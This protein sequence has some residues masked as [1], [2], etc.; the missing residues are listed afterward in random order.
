MTENIALSFTLNLSY[1]ILFTD[2]LFE[3][4]NLL[5]SRQI[6][7]RFKQANCLVYID[8]NVASN[9]VDLTRNIVRYF[10]NKVFI[11]LSSSPYVIKGGEA[12]KNDPA[13]L[14]QLYMD[15]LDAGID[16]H[17]CI[18]AIGGG[19][20]LDLVGYAAAT[21]HRGVPLI[22]IPTTVLAQN[23]AGIGVKTGINF[24]G[25]KNSIGAFCTPLAVLCDFQFL[26]TLSE[27]DKRAGTAEAIKVALIKNVDFFNWIEAHI[28]E[29]NRFEAG[30][31]KYL[32]RTC[33]KLHADKIAKG[34]DPYERGN[35]RPLDYG[36]WSAHKLEM[37]SNYQIKHGEAV[38]IGMLI[39]ACYAVEM[40]FLLESDYQRIGQLLYKL[41]F[42]LYHPELHTLTAS[43]ENILFHG[44]SE[45]REHI[46]G[47]LNL[48]LLTAIG[49]TIEVNEMNTDVLA[50]CLEKIRNADWSK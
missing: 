45:F 1:P 30:A 38:A 12:C 47:E 16:R 9:T 24:Q 6:L 46:G 42:T 29:L 40:G 34:G 35:S 41:G 13:L 23:D 27:R 50:T 7:S 32:V 22:R 43:G 11:N 28:D 20:L 31:V 26:N 4:D 8:E 15:I 39:D 2:H 37:L 14:Q 3:L 19:A 48:T 21:M 33:A 18:I 10:E 44:L 17:S 25:R 36:H 5:L 49:V